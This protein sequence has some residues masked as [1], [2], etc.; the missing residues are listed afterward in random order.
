MMI[1]VYDRVENIV[2][3]NKMFVTSSFSFTKR[4]KHFTKQ[5]FFGQD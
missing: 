4:L 3:K 1:S 2:G 5:Q